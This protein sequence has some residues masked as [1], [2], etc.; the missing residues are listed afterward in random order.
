MRKTR[1][2]GILLSAALAISWSL[3]HAQSGNT[4]TGIVKDE[5][6]RPLPSVSVIVKKTNAATTTDD[7]GKFTLPNV[8]AK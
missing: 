1:L 5:S 3:V 4:I 2:V 6:G 7:N 8:G